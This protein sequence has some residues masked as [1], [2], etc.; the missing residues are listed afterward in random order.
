MGRATKYVPATK[1]PEHIF[2]YPITVDSSD[3]GG[4]QMFLKAGDLIVATIEGIGALTLLLP[5]RPPRQ[6]PGP[7]AEEQRP[8]A[9][10]VEPRL[11]TQSRRG[12]T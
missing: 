10:A 2:G 4:K 12:D 5:S 8:E 11:V 9:P 3:R 6:A 1:A 7:T